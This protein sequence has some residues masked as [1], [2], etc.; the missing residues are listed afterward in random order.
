M[1]T[2]P[3]CPACGTL[4]NDDGA[5]GWICSRRGGCGSEWHT[6]T[7]QVLPSPAGMWGSIAPNGRRVHAFVRWDVYD[8]ETACGVAVAA[9]GLPYGSE[10]DWDADVPSP[11]IPCPACRKALRS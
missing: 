9:V 10:P 8:Y 5:E 7:I 3:R 4:L 1:T 11:P 6:E 2:Y